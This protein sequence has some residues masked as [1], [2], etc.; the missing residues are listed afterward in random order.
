MTNVGTNGYVWSS[1]SY[2]AGNINAGN[3]NFNSG[4]VNPLN[5]NNRANGF[6]VRC[7]QHLR[8]AVFTLKRSGN[9]RL[10]GPEWRSA[11]AS[12]SAADRFS[13]PLTE[14]LLPPMREGS[15]SYTT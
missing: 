4:N 13:N 15:A 6:P 14:C 8:R 5:G 9:E 3:L 1:S 12:A 10:T 7:V 2:A 11:T